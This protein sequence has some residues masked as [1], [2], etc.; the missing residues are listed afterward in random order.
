MSEPSKYKTIVSILFER[1]GKRVLTHAQ[2]DK[3]DTPEQA[4]QY[5]ETLHAA[6]VIVGWRVVYSVN[7][8][9]W[10]NH[11]FVCYIPDEIQDDKTVERMPCGLP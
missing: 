8:D 9:S 1:D 4:R 11:N 6:K 2:S 5:G 10:Y 7:G 3:F